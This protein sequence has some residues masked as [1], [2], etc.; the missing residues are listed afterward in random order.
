MRTLIAMVTCT[1]IESANV[2]WKS[3][4][5]NIRSLMKI[6]SS[7]IQGERLVIFRINALIILIS[8]S[9]IFLSI[10]EYQLCVNDDVLLL[11]LHRSYSCIFQG[12]VIRLAL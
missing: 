2:M 1:A 8:T 9:S 3:C 10:K 7:F 12:S 4:F 11:Q 5:V 6:N